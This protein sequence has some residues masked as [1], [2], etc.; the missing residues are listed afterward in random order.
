MF[1]LNHYQKDILFILL[2][3]ALQLV[4]SIFFP[5]RNPDAESGVVEVSRRFMLVEFNFIEHDVS[6][7]YFPVLTIIFALL[8][9][10]LLIQKHRRFALIYGV[11][12]VL[13]AKAYFLNGLYALHHTY[14]NLYT[15]GLMQRKILSGDDV[16]AYDIS[17]SLLCLLLLIKV[18]I[19]AHDTYM[20]R[21]VRNNTAK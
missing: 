6:A 11:A 15:E 21:R 5:F 4:F 14:D 3:I 20:K 1:K 2:L 9:I 12:I 8:L 13:V 7:L 19:Y 18:V 10:F 16:L 17:L